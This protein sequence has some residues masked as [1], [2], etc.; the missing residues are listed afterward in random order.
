MQKSSTGE[1]LHRKLLSF[2]Y[3]AN[4]IENMFSTV[5][6]YW[7]AGRNRFAEALRQSHCYLQCAAL[8][9]YRSVYVEL[10]F[11]VVEHRLSASYVVQQIVSIACAHIEHIFVIFEIE[12]GKLQNIKL[13]DHHTMRFHMQRMSS[14]NREIF[15]F[16]PP[17]PTPFWE[18]RRERWSNGH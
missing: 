11:C 15:V 7:I 18:T 14:S 3:R 8:V 17:E 10:I 9:R 5:I 12:H 6:A 2:G 13:K 4:E 1:S 16:A